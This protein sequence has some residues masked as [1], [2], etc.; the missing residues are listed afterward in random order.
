[1]FS[2]SNS[3]PDF[4]LRDA[5]FELETR[6]FN[7]TSIALYRTE[8]DASQ[9]KGWV[10]NP[11]VEMILNRWRNVNHMSGDASPDDDEMLKLMLDYDDGSFTIQDLGEDVKR[12]GVREP[13][14][15]TWDGTLIDGNRRKFAVMWALSSK[16]GTSPEQHHRLARTPMFVLPE[17]AS[18][19]DKQS[20]IIQENYA[21]SLKREWPQVVTNGRIYRRYQ[22][23][24][25]HFPTEQELDIRRRV[26]REFPRFTVTD[27]RDRINTWNLIEEFRTDYGDDDNEDDLEAGINRSFQYFRQANDTYRNRNVF[28]EPEFKE[29]LF[30]GIQ[31]D[32]FPSFASVRRLEDIY[33]NPQATEIFLGGEGLSGRALTSHF[34]RA[35]AEAGREEATRNLTLV[36]RLESII[37]GIDN[38]TSAELAEIPASLRSRLESTLQRIIAQATV[39]TDEPVDA[40]AVE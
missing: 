24:S 33:R 27:I 7:G 40:D 28:A 36:R 16:G 3:R 10:D 9:I 26:Q 19:D 23:F 25:N 5:D 21:E 14:I 30:R 8:G 20:I 39:S 11:R 12:N 29:L 31:Q 17:G 13:I 18:N 34:N 32:L 6:Y 4:V 37:D 38:L 1:M 35:T 2:M 22:D 15:V